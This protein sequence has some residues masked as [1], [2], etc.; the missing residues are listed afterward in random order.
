MLQIREEIC[1]WVALGKLAG[2]LAEEGGEKGRLMKGAEEKV[3]PMFYSAGPS[4][5][6]SFL[7]ACLG[8]W[9]LNYN[10]RTRGGEVGKMESHGSQRFDLNSNG[11][12]W[13]LVSISHLVALSLRAL[14]SNSKKK[15][16]KQNKQTR[17][18]VS[19]CTFLCH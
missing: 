5:Q 8:K 13:E 10:K 1:S 12:Q 18:Q 6:Q 19:R 11:I 7:P 17:S 2:A 4:E 3:S 14:E 9:Q 15:H 16:P